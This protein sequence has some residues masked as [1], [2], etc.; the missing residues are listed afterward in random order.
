MLSDLTATQVAFLQISVLQAVA[1]V[2][3][4][5]GAW[6]VRGDRIALAHWAGYAALSSLTWWMLALNLQSPPLLAVLVGMCAAI[7][8]RGGIRRFVGRGPGW[9]APLPMLVLV[10]LVG[11]L[12]DAPAWRH[13]QAAVNF[14]V[15]AALYVGMALDIG[16]HARDDLQWRW[17]W[18]LSLPLLLGAFGFGTRALRALLWPESLRAE[19]NV[20]S[21]LNVASALSYVV[22]VL[23]MHATLMALVVARLVGHLQRLARRDGLTGLLNRRAMHDLLDLQMRQRR[24]A[25]DAFSV[26]MIDIDDFK[27]VNDTHGHE[28][29]DRALLH[30]ARLM[31]QTLRAEDRLGR[32]GG[33][34]FLVLLPASDR[35]RAHAQ[36]ER[37]RVEVQRSPLRIDGLS[38]PLSVSI[39]L[40][41]WG[42]SVEDAARLLAR[43]DAALYRAK[44]L[45]R[46]RVE[47]AI[48]DAA[49]SCALAPSRSA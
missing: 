5:L 46:N 18:A 44:R 8:L 4:A 29:G 14:G 17:P 43:A 25:D 30:I 36:A 33:E 12:A 42:G 21:T 47:P 45:G 32:F 1:A 40:A 22:L 24:R 3:W 39:G 16:R 2:V 23:L 28:A 11:A 35:Q 38:V 6:F 13:L 37:L 7:A 31:A 26:L 20:H 48:D 34:E 49:G 15:L 41:Q 10:L 19:M 9:Q 27:A